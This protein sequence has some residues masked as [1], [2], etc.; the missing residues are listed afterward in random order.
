MPEH[1][2]DRLFLHLV[3][4]FEAQAMVQ[5]GKVVDPTSGEARRDLEG[6]KGT[7]AIIEMLQGKTKGNLTDREADAL[8]H[9]L[10][11]LRMNYVDELRKGE[12]PS[13]EDTVPDAATP[14]QG[15]EDKQQEAEQQKEDETSAPD[16][17]EEPD[18]E[19]VAE[20]STTD[21]G[22]HGKSKEAENAAP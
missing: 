21:S 15:A 17:P 3:M 6:A 10:T 2:V 7:I 20:Q 1:D 4:V 16:E 22:D 19:Q 8:R 14:P 18:S 12:T 5:L 11:S 13:E 9:V